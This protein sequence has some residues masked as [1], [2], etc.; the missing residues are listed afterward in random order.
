M[1]RFESNPLIYVLRDKDRWIKGANFSFHLCSF[2]WKRVAAWQALSLVFG[3]GK[4]VKVWYYSGDGRI[5]ITSDRC[6]WL[7][8]PWYVGGGRVCAAD[9]ESAPPPSVC[10]PLFCLQQQNFKPRREPA[11]VIRT[12]GRRRKWP[13]G[14]PWGSFWHCYIFTSS[15][16][17][18]S[19]RCSQKK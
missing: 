8:P 2:G 15:F 5:L 10:W 9:D 11:V 17:A 18:R 3:E 14:Q 19:L 1:F 4:R 12:V 16:S 6:L 7:W 13:R